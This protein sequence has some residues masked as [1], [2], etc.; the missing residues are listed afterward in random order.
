MKLAD[1]VI[2]ALIAAAVLRAVICC[3]RRKHSC[4]CCGDCSQCSGCCA[5]SKAD[6]S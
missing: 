6:E 3:V 4:S 1:I 2:L 5:N